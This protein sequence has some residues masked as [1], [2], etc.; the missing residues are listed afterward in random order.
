[1]HGAGGSYNTWFK[2]IKAFKTN[3]NVLLLDLRGHGNSE[4]S[5]TLKD[6]KYTFD[7]LANDILCLLDYLEIKKSHFVAISL[8]TI[9]VRQLA[10]MQPQRVSSLTLAGAIMKLNVRSWLLVH[11]GNIFKYNL[12]YIILY[13]FF[14]YIIMPRNNHKTSRDIFI[15]E[16]KKLNQLEFIKWFSLASEVNPVLKIFRKHELPKP[17][18]YI[19]GNQ[20]AMFLPSIKKMVKKQPHFS[21]LIIAKNCGHVVNLDSAYFFN[22][23]VVSFIHQYAV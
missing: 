22:D 3:F 16:A 10:Q 18:L 5:L 20:D 6:V 4:G 21:T 17:T 19:M 2:Q 11:L 1:V 12:P 7:F 9:I 14:A 15:N 23:T 8:G 13:T